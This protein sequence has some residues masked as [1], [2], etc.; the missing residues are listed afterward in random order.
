[1]ATVVCY[2]SSNLEP[3]PVPQLTASQS[4]LENLLETQELQDGQVDGGV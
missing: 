4:I 3:A 1:M 2:Q